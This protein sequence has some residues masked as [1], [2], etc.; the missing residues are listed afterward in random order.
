MKIQI[1]YFNFVQHHNIAMQQLVS[2]AFKMLLAKVHV[3]VDK[4]FRFS[5]S[6]R[7]VLF[8]TPYVTLVTCAENTK[9]L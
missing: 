7:S 3:A 1:H 4:Q 6:E 8:S 5:T 2:A 9:N